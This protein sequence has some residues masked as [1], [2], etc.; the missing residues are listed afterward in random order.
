MDR[1]RVLIGAGALALVGVGFA[2]TGGRRAFW[3][4]L[5]EDVAEQIDVETAHRMAEAGEVILV[6]IRRPDEWQATGSPASGHRLDMRRDDFIEA[7]LELTGGERD[8]PVALICARGVR[9]SRLTNQLVAAGFVRVIDVP[10]GM[11]GS[12]AGPGWIGA[13][14][15]VIR[16]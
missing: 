6:D 15:P 7:L 10:E 9:S 4:L 13:G 11:L 14:L 3:S 1:R 12:A 8:A 16:G 2:A 5:S